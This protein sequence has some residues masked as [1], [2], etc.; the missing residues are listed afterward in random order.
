M[1]IELT[2]GLVEGSAASGKIETHGNDVFLRLP[3]GQA[4]LLGTK[5][6]PG[7]VKIIRGKKE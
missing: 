7:K 2:P 6:A 1:N 5:P 4:L 3:N